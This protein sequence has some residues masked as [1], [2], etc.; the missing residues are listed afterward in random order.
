MSETRPDVAPDGRAVLESLVENHQKAPPD[1]ADKAEILSVEHIDCKRFNDRELRV[2]EREESLEIS[3][4]DY[5]DRKAEFR[6]NFESRE[7]DVPDGLTREIYRYPVP[8]THRVSN[9][10]ECFGEGRL[11]CQTCDSDGD[12]TCSYCDGSGFSD[13][14]ECMSCDGSGT[15]EC[16]DCAGDGCPTCDS[17][18]TVE[19]EECQGS[20]YSH[21]SECTRCDGTGVR[22]CSDCDGEGQVRCSTC[23]GEGTT[24]KV[25]VRV[26]EFFVREKVTYDAPG[27]PVKFLEE[28]DG[29][30]TRE[31][32]P[33]TDE[34]IRRE[35]VTHE[36]PV[37]K[38]KYRYTEPRL[39][40]KDTETW[41]AYSVD[42]VPNCEDYP[43]TG[44]HRTLRGIDIPFL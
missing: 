38:V 24:H 17:T 3:H 25:A 43:R 18:G 40:G 41:V 15:V 7:D 35:V 33:P 27:V 23:Q 14:Y 26:R 19:C 9:C 44:I 31:S 16:P 8:D 36:I 1:L 28:A 13:R 4:D 32:R 37:T 11:P 2:R 5:P 20:G 22:D 34:G 30:T 12:V 6:E 42:G 10:S 39:F 21:T 29:T